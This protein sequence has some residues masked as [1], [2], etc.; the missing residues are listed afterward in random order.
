[1]STSTTGPAVPVAALAVAAYGAVLG[2]LFPIV[3]VLSVADVSGGLSVAADSGAL[4]NTAQNVGS[5]A[6][7][8][9]APSITMGIGRG[10]MMLVSGIGFAIASIACALAPTLGWMLAARTL[11]GVFGG[12][13]PL[14]FMMIVMSSLRP[15]R[16]QFEGMT[17]FGGSTTLFFGMAASLG[18]L[19]VDGFGWR[20]LFWAQAVAVV[21]YVIAASRVLPGETGRPETLRDIDWESYL[22]LTAG[23]GMVVVAMSEGE[24]HFWLDAWWVPA[25]CLGGAVLTGFAVRGLLTRQGRKLVVLD[26]FRRQTF[27]WGILLSVFFR[28]GTMFVIFIVPSFLGRLQGLRP[29]E[30]GQ[31]LMLMTPAAAVGLVAAWRLARMVDGRWLLSAGLACFAL[32]AWSCVGIGPDWAVEQLRVAAL[33]A[34]VG[35][36]LFSVGVLRFAVV[37]AT[38][39]DGPSV[40]IVFNL[41]RVL[42]NVAGLAILMH[43]VAEREKANSAAIVEALGATSGETAQRLAATASALSRLSA[44][45]AAA[46]NG[47]LTALGRAASGQAF[48]L[49]FADALGV[50]AIVLALGAILVWALPRIPLEGAPNLQGSPS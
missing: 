23:L 1:M 34:G 17:L 36:A 15:G 13:L 35:L 21:P 16:G 14:M 49:A 6:G 10:R 41:A 50:T 31:V 11:H 5:V 3:V 42:G 48:T 46:E 40:G 30:T 39:V 24:R 43:L 38:I 9:I 8:L 32:A 44:D 45:P 19:L 26:V 28:F 18:A 4:V 25:L 7:I 29:S 22:P 2:S 47:A 33:V 12:I 37:G 20:A 27:T